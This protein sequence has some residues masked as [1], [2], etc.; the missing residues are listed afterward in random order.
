MGVFLKVFDV[1]WPKRLDFYRME[2]SAKRGVDWAPFECQVGVFF[3]LKV[4]KYGRERCQSTQH[5]TS[6][7]ICIR[8]NYF[9][10]ITVALR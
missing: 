3:S 5:H 2:L 9:K 6:D 1:E 4:F 7:W 10:S 8:R